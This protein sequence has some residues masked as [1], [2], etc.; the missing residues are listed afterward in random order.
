MFIL[1]YDRFAGSFN[2]FR[3]SRRVKQVR[4]LAR[5][6]PWML[7]SAKAYRNESNTM[8]P[9][10]S[11][12]DRDDL[13]K[14]A[15][16]E[17]FGQGNAQLPEPPMLMMDRITEISEDGGEHGKGH[18]IAEFD[19]KPDLWFFDCHFPGNPIMPG[20]LGLDGLWQL[21]GFNLGWRGWQGR[22]YAL[23]VG[24]VKLTGMVRPDRKM[25]TYRVNFTKAVQTRRLTMGVADGIVEA[26]GEVIYQVK[27]MKVALSES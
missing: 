8:S 2:S 27:D 22:G 11:S 5:S 19:I 18:V 9:Y 26:D 15:R 21:T 17:L 7:E 3:H 14:C 4:I 10:P 20:C 1:S 16:G 25:L 6:E 13:L 12:F 24:E 23:G